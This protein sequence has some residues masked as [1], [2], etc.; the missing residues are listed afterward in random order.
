MARALLVTPGVRLSYLA[1]ILML[2]SAV[3]CGPSSKTRIPSDPPQT[4]CAPELVEVDITDPRFVQHWDVIGY[5]TVEDTGGPDTD[6]KQRF[7]AYLRACLLGGTSLGY[8]R[9]Q[10][11][12]GVPTFPEHRKGVTYLVLRPRAPAGARTY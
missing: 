11:V 1:L 5:V 3:G 10:P 12:P 4:G 7:L 8:A 6:D 9:N 2:A